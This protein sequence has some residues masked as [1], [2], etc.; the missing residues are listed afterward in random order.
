MAA[1]HETSFNLTGDGEP[2]RVSAYSVTANFF[3]LLGVQPLLGR[4]FLTEGRSTRREQGRRAQLQPLA[5]ALR[6]RSQHPQPRHFAQ[7]REAYGR[8]RDAREFSVF[9]SDTRL[10][11]PIALDQEDMANRGGHYL[12]VVARLKP[13]VRVAGAG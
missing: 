10:W 11:V 3:P 6:R 9:E 2:E 1:S 5:D 13:G 7:R 12:K 8:R 4:S